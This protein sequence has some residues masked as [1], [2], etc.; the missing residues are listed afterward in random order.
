MNTITEPE[1]K[2][3]IAAPKIAAVDD[4]D[5]TS[6]D[7]PT[8]KWRPFVLAML[9]VGRILTKDVWVA[10]EI[11]AEQISR[12]MDK[13]IKEVGEFYKPGE[14]RQQFD[15]HNRFFSGGGIVVEGTELPYPYR[16]APHFHFTFTKLNPPL[17]QAQPENT[18]L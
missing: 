17:N 9:R 18:N 4:P 16:S 13:R 10:R 11:R 3:I 8:L 12:I 14:I 15:Y 6:I 2:S 7:D 5:F 1:T